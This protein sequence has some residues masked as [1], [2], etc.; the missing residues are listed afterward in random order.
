MTSLFARWDRETLQRL[1]FPVLFGPT[2]NWYMRS[3]PR[4]TVAKL[5]EIGCASQSADVQENFNLWM[6][7]VKRD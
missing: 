7:F 1:L 5:Y 6:Q 4:S 2:M 3:M